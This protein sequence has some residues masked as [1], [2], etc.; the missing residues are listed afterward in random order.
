MDL[1]LTKKIVN[2]FFGPKYLSDVRQIS[3]FH[4]QTA[5]GFIYSVRQ[6]LQP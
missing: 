5:P 1:I 2:Y 3:G 4:A 6:M